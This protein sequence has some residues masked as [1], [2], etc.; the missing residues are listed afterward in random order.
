MGKKGGG[1]KGEGEGERRGREGREGGDGEECEGE[2][3]LPRR[4]D[5][6]P[7]VHLEVLGTAPLRR[8]LGVLPLRPPLGR[9]KIGTVQERVEDASVDAVEHVCCRVRARPW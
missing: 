9:G 7:L 1:G 4:L 2:G 3:A 5:A 6:L 8:R